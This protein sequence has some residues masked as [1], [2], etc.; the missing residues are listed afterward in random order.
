MINKDEQESES[1]SVE[2]IVDDP[3]ATEPMI[4]LCN[5]YV[6]FLMDEEKN[7]IVVNDEIKEVNNYNDCTKINVIFEKCISNIFLKDSFCFIYLITPNF[8]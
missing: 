1:E 8:R 6:D 5:E 2:D 3:Y 4:D 7:K